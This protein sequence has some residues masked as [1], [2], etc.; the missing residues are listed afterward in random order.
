VDRDFVFASKNGEPLDTPTVTRTFQAALRRADLPRQP[1]H[2]LRHASATLM[3]ED[4]QE[5]VVVSRTLGHS[6]ISTTADLYAHVT[7]ATL[8][9][10]A[11]R[12]DGILRPKADIA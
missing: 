8:Q 5:L 4:G 2:H 6:T 1:F 10:S 12:M 11:A 3:L 9:R 7:P